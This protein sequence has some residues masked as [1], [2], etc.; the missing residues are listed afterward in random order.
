MKMSNYTITAESD[1]T[2]FVWEPS[3]DKP[4]ADFK[5]KEETEA[6]IRRCEEEGELKREFQ[7]VVETFV[8]RTTQQLEIPKRE[9][10]EMIR[11][12][13]NLHN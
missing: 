10:L 9:R 6:Y 3:L 8:E 12:W 13:C 7:T 2:W 11:D 4:L 1:G 5:T